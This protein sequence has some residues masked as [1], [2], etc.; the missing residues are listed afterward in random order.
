MLEY[1]K[2]H[3]SVL[4]LPVLLLS[5]SGLL[6]QT[7]EDCVAQ[8]VLKAKG[9]K[10]LAEI[11]Q[12]CASALQKSVGGTETQWMDCLRLRA[13]SA[14]DTATADSLKAECEG[15]IERGELIPERVV[16]T[17]KTE[18][19]P[20]VITPLRQNYILPYTYNRNPNQEPYQVDEQEPMMNEE[21]KLQL[22][23]MVPL[24]YGDLFTANDGLYFGFTLK[25]FWQVYNHDISAPFRETNYRP[26]VFYQLPLPIESRN[27]AWYGRVGLEHESNGRSQ[28]LSRSWNRA[29]VAVGYLRPNWALGIQ[30]WYR[31]P[32]DKKPDD[33]DPS[34]PPPPDGDD[35]PDIEDF[36]GHYEITGAYRWDKMEFAGLFR[37]NFDEGHGAIEL[38]LS[39]P[40]WGRLRG[41]AQ[42]FD[43][44]GESLIDYN[45][46]NQRF[47]I[48]VL[49]TDLL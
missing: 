11:R 1:T 45:H 37:R 10:P 23:I 22:S 46:R 19:N 43:G 20:Y 9:S 14:D 49:L 30:P 12:K 5:A 4:L 40:L 27:G 44:Y 39:F 36:M 24:T 33:G 15:V 16:Q 48:G 38:G 34:T 47:G 6:A 41:Y 21:A 26:E 3:F 32:E 28:L 31:F 25:S 7:Q 18:A 2:R 35:N 17:R 8:G 29:Y 42:Y 13:L